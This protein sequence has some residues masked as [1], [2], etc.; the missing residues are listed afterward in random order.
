MS[1]NITANR[2]QSQDKVEAEIADMVRTNPA[3]AQA[4]LISEAQKLGITPK[5]LAS[6]VAQRVVKATMPKDFRDTIPALDARQAISLMR[7]LGTDF[8]QPLE[9]QKA[10]LQNATLSRLG[11]APDLRS[12]MRA[13]F[14][15]NRL[16]AEPYLPMKVASNRRPLS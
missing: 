10:Q 4:K 16:T 12:M 7:G 2:R 6:G 11:V 13:Q 14:A 1:Q 15:D 3:E 9:T 5:E 8:G